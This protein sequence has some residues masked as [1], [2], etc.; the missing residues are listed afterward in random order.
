MDWPLPG[1]KT[2]VKL[3][4]IFIVIL[5]SYQSATSFYGVFSPEIPR[6]NP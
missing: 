5:H 3:K 2:E 1:E 6:K 4:I